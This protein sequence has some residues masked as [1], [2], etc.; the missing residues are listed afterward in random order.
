M[1]HANGWFWSLKVFTCFYDIST[2]F[3]IVKLLQ[4]K[5]V[6]AKIK[7]HN[8][9]T[10]KIASIKFNLKEKQNKQIYLIYVFPGYYSK[11]FRS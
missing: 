7:Y 8:L 1:Y 11:L 2:E 10:L 3:I 6:K 4:K 9:N 5:V